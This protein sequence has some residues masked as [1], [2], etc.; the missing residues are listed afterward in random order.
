MI[1]ENNQLQFTYSV[2]GKL[3]IE[4]YRLRDLS[5]T[6]GRHTFDVNYSITGSF[7]VETD[8]D[9]LQKIE[10]NVNR[11]N[12]EIVDP[13]DPLH[14]RVQRLVSERIGEIER[15]LSSLQLTLDELSD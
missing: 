11:L 8:L 2:A 9:Y 5:F 10:E 15:N 12:S 14:V 13:I 6:S 3:P 7:I 4:G 1:E